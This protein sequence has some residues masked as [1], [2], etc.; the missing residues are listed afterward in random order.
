M[1]IKVL[2]CIPKQESTFEK[3]LY[4]I[5]DKCKNLDFD[6]LVTPQEYFGGAVMMSNNMSFKESDL[7]PELQ[8]ISQKYNKALIVG[9]LE[10][11]R[12]RPNKES[13]WFIDK[14]GE[15]KGKIYKFALPGYD[16]VVTKGSGDVEP[17]ID[18]QNRFQTF[19]ICGLKVTGVFCWEVFSNILWTGIAET[20][21]D[22]VV[23]M[24]KF[25]VAAWP[26][27][28]IVDNKKTVVKFG[29][30]GWKNDQDI[31]IDRLYM[32]NLHQVM[33]PIVC[34]TN[35]WNL[36]PM[37]KPLCGTIS[38]IE[39][40]A[41]DT[42]YYPKKADNIKEIPEKIIIDEIDKNKVR[43]SL[44]SKFKYKDNVGEFPPYKD[45]EY[46]MLM[47]IKRLEKRLITGKEQTRLKKVLNKWIIK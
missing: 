8:D 19:K 3:K 26:S 37:S 14:G 36:K 17:E 6:I 2:S 12:N 15:L 31:W 43:Y 30:A 39:G 25:G 45:M 34:S 10:A 46:T 24:I 20:Y 5:Q 28:Q 38:Q 29:Y 42:L 32:A 22:L 9:V 23:S 33:C 11:F 18:L 4:W 16:H 21:P 47:K 41:K 7:L 44:D 35:S 40:Q 27:N 13:I 1:S